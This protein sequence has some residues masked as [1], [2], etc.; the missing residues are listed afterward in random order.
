MSTINKKEISE[1]LVKAM[2]R[3][4]LR[5]KEAG[6]LLNLNPCYISMAQNPKYWDSMGK[7]A[8]VRLEEW[9]QTNEKISVFE[10]PEG[11]D[12]WKPKEKSLSIQEVEAPKHAKRKIEA[13]AEVTQ[14][15]VHNVTELKPSK[16]KKAEKENSTEDANLMYELLSAR[17]ANEELH[18]EIDKLR[19]A[20]NNYE[21]KPASELTVMPDQATMIPIQLDLKINI[22]VSLFGKTVNMEAK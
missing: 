15:T 1:A 7:A 13:K 2:A 22:E 8:W 21:L 4:E 19:A 6:R 16:K 14:E 18:K 10:I 3:E 17:T 12:I 20:I 5:S 9:C 11:E